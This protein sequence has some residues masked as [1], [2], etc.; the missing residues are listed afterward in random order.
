MFSGPRD[1]V[2]SIR[3]QISRHDPTHPMHGIDV[4]RKNRRDA[5]LN[6]FGIAT[7]RKGIASSRRSYATSTRPLTTNPTGGSRSRA[8]LR[9]LVQEDT[10]PSLR[11]SVLYASLSHQIAVMF[12]RSL[13]VAVILRSDVEGRVAQSMNAIIAR[14]Y[15]RRWRR[16]VGAASGER[17]TAMVVAQKGVA[18]RQRVAFYFWANRW[19]CLVVARRKRTATLIACWESWRE[20]HLPSACAT[21]M[22][23][24]R[25][26]ALKR[27]VG[28]WVRR[29]AMAI[30][31]QKGRRRTLRYS[32]LPSPDLRV[33]LSMQL[34]DLGAC[35]AKLAAGLPKTRTTTFSLLALAPL[36]HHIRSLLS[37]RRKVR[38][39]RR[40]KRAQLC[41]ARWRTRYLSREMM[42]A[43][44]MFRCV[45]LAM[46]WLRPVVTMMG[47]KSNKLIA[48][49]PREIAVWDMKQRE[50]AMR[51]GRNT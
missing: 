50:R 27:V 32:D 51:K 26:R 38:S 5:L 1:V 29:T 6:T 3:S 49:G 18:V 46:R 40:T 43:A 10:P 48:V 35:V 13:R 12:L 4:F 21:V 37:Q 24:V 19:R 16:G 15:L 11:Q 41:F 42:S 47:S 17:S 8:I 34:L 2:A 28:V 44:A 39:S 14:Q 23:R 33:A 31:T 20:V 25:C 30:A 45:R 36:S 9:R 22:R 7:L